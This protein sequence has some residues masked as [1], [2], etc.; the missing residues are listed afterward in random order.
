MSDD[1]EREIITGEMSEEA[2]EAAAL[3]NDTVLAA[4]L[5]ALYE[6]FRVAGDKATL[7]SSF[8]AAQVSYVN[9]MN[10]AVSIHKIAQVREQIVRDR[11]DKHTPRT[12]PG[13]EDDGFMDPEN[14]NDPPVD[15]DDPVPE[16]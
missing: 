11:F 1:Y 6:A 3:A 16:L 7:S 4:R 12:D 13:F 10:V 15:A 5:E 8:E 2:I 14:S 9:A